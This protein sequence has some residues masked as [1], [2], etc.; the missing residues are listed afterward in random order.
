M[1]RRFSRM[2]LAVRPP[3]CARPSRDARHFIYTQPVGERQ[4]DIGHTALTLRRLHQTVVDLPHLP[5][6]SAYV[7]TDIHAVSRS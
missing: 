1:L 6:V 7:E 2:P 5:F 4:G 3:R